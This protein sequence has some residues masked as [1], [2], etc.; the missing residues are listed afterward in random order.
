MTIQQSKL[1]ELLDKQSATFKETVI[2]HNPSVGLTE[3]LAPYPRDRYGLMTCDYRKF[4]RIL[5]ETSTGQASTENFPDLLRMGI[6]FD[7]FGGFN[8]MQTTYERIVKRRPSTLHQEEYQ[9]DTGIGLLGVVPEGSE[10]PE[11]AITL[12]GGT[13]IPNYKRGFIIPVTE[14]LQRFDK[15]GKVRDLANQMGRA[16][17]MT[18]EQAV[19]NVLTTTT[20]Y[21]VK[22]NNDQAGNNQQSLGFTSVNVN[23]ALA[24]M[25][26]QKDSI[27]GQYLGVVPNLLICGP[28]LERFA[29]MLLTTADLVR[30]GGSA[31]NEVYGVGQSNPFF[32][33]INQIIVSPLFAASYQWAL[34]DTSRA[35][36]FQE[37]DGLQV[38]TQAAGSSSDSWFNRDVIKYKVRDWFGC[39]MRDDR[40]AFLST[41]TAA[42]AAA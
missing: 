15:L 41:S 28:L 25:M 24:L 33:T 8:E 1:I 10:Y 29:K 32:G 9:D 37:V 42:P 23:T 34:V 4:D 30:A 16:A 2:D 38:F 7:V 36:Y 22:N 5:T 14:E 27:S 39:G 19:M 6:Q 11:A 12:A 21:N 35:V 3:D 20:N 40:F 13:I 17:R 18:R 31:T 26:T